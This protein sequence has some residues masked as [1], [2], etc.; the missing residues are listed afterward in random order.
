MSSL[1]D[2]S[3]TVAAAELAKAAVHYAREFEGEIEVTLSEIRELERRLSEATARLKNQANVQQ[4]L[5]LFEANADRLLCPHCWIVDGTSSTLE[6]M[7]FDNP[8]DDVLRCHVCG[9]DYGV[10]LNV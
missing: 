1:D 8:D 9:R 6:P 5:S 4:R 7:R 10:S 2:T 3:R